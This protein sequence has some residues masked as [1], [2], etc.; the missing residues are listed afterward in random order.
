MP[1]EKNDKL[2]ELKTS[3][4]DEE[5]R[6][7]TELAE[8]K[9][10]VKAVEDDIAKV[11]AG[12][13]ALS[14]RSSSSNGSSRKSSPSS[15]QAKSSSKSSAKSASASKRTSSPTLVPGQSVDLVAIAADSLRLHGTMSRE[16]LEA[17]VAARLRERGDSI[18]NLTM[19]LDEALRDPRF[20]NSAAGWRLAEHTDHSE[21]A[22][23]HEHA[24]V[25]A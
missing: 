2:D 8:A 1:N 12:L 3:L 7:R 13:A 14:G 10:R 11:K 22:Q 9:K 19:E 17:D 16:S 23:V 25:F 5:A 24:S 4:R 20:S 15:S 6:L 18:G 21:H